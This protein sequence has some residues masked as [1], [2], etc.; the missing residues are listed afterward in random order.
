MA[1]CVPS[2]LGPQMDRWLAKPRWYALAVIVRNASK[3]GVLLQVAKV[4]KILNESDGLEGEHV[5]LLW[6]LTQKVEHHCQCGAWWTLPV[7]QLL[8]TSLVK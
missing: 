7:R 6:D 5:E 1:T 4:L 8:R 2:S 3:D